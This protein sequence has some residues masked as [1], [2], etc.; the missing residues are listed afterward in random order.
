MQGWAEVVVAGVE[1]RQPSGGEG[2]CER[3]GGC[4]QYSMNSKIVDCLTDEEAP[5]KQNGP[6]IR[7]IHFQFKNLQGNLEN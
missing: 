6:K 4:R 1:E 7:K 3:G 2:W 5:K